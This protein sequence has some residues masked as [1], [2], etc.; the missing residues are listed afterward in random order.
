MGRS[1]AALSS[2]WNF[3]L[4]AMP[5]KGHFEVLRVYPEVFRHMPEEI[6]V[7]VP[8]TG[9]MFVPSAW[10]HAHDDDGQSKP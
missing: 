9:R 4:S 1:K 10:R 3:D 8:A 5:K 7:I 6:Y 2:D